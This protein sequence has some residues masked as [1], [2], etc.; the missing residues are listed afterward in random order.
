MH[1]ADRQQFGAARLQPAVA[2]VALALGTVPVAARVVGEEAFSA[3]RTF[4]D[5]SA[6][7][8]GPAIQNSVER[9]PVLAV[10]THP[11]TIDECV[12]GGTDYVGH[13][14]RRPVHAIYL[15]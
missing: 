9:L 10:E 1:I 6:E 11:G 15:G 12:S 2:R 14:Q 5:V 4:I 13:L 7:S 3:P 8:G